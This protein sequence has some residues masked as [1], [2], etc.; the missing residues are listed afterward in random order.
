M[1]AAGPNTTEVLRWIFDG[2]KLDD[3]EEVR[4]HTVAS[5]TL[6]QSFAP[7]AWLLTISSINRITDPLLQALYAITLV[8]RCLLALLQKLPNSATGAKYLA[9]NQQV[10]IPAPDCVD[11]EP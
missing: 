9:E 8:E 2:S 10:S 5:H 4:T 11:S 3:E 1:P 7:S 6:I